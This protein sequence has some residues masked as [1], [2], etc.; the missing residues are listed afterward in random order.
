MKGSPPNVEKDER[1]NKEKTMKRKKI[2]KGGEEVQDKRLQ[3]KQVENVGR[4][5]QKQEEK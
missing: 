2:D 1:R 5:E 3:R 4:R